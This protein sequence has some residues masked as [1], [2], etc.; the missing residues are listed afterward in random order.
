MIHKHLETCESTSIILKDTYEAQPD[1]ATP[2]LV[3]TS[4]QVAGLGRMGNSWIG[5]EN[6][7]ALS[8]TL[9]SNPSVPTLTSLEV[10]VALVEFLNAHFK[11]NL[12]LKWPNDI[13]GPELHK[14][15]G[16]LLQSLRGNLYCCG[17]G[18]NLSDPSGELLKLERKA[19]Q[20]P[21]GSI[22][23]SSA[24]PLTSVQKKELSHKIANSILDRVYELRS[25]DFKRV[26]NEHCAHL[27]Q[28]VEIRDAHSVTS[29]Y[30]RGV[31][32]QG[33]A[34]IED[35]E[36]KRVYSGSLFIL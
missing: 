14:V 20:Y 36:I 31:G 25:G 22:L 7:L 4:H 13:L 24:Q 2:L 21:A 1:G 10:G 8:F 28:R 35:G 32:P 27:N 6:A 19:G 15:G 3:S 23:E 17:I 9:H 5:L 30:F 16:I 12:K 18:I 33:E 11:T 26:W 29:G 34:Q